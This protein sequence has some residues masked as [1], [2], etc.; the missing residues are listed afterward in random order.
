[1]PCET[2]PHPARSQL[3]RAAAIGSRFC[4][5]SHA[6]SYRTCGRKR[7]N[8]RWARASPVPSA[9]EAGVS[10]RSSQRALA[11]QRT[12]PTPPNWTAGCPRLFV[13]SRRRNAERA[14]RYLRTRR[15]TADPATAPTPRWQ[16]DEVGVCV[17]GVYPHGAQ[18]HPQIAAFG[19]DLPNSLQ[20]L[21]FGVVGRRDRKQAGDRD[22]ERQLVGPQRLG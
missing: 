17:R 3:A 18:P 6:L 13:R 12:L 19:S 9:G 14:L 20:Q 7:A 5:D 10:L 16:E 11:T 4:S 1:M 22:A 21:I 2:S 15:S 8:S